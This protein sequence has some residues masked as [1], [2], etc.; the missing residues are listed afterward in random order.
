[1]VKIVEDLA[2][3]SSI[4]TDMEGSVPRTK[5]SIEIKSNH[6]VLLNL[7]LSNN[8]GN[9]NDHTKARHES[10]LELDLFA[11]RNPSFNNY[12]RGDDQRD[13]DFSC[14]FCKQP[15]TSFLRPSLSFNKRELGISTPSTSANCCFGESF[16]AANKVA[17]SASTSLGT[18]SQ[19][20]D[21]S[22]IDLS[23]KL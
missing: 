16:Q 5:P 9:N 1:M 7:K 17:A 18:D 20:K 19:Y 10:N 4:L 14:N 8:D 12:P 15:L 23:L 2:E 6:N 3:L 13:K 11:Q 21:V 22:G